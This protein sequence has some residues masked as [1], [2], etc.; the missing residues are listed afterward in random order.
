MRKVAIGFILMGGLWLPQ[1][2]FGQQPATTQEDP[3]QAVVIKATEQTIDG[4]PG[5]E[6]EV[7]FL[8]GAQSGQTVTIGD[9]ETVTNTGFKTF[10]QGDRVFVALIHH[11]DGSDRYL[12]LDHVRG[13]NLWWFLALFIVAVIW[14]SRWRGVRSL[15][16]LAF[17]FTVII[18]W[19][20]PQIANGANPVVV[21]LLG[22][23]V[24]LLLNFV[25]IEGFSRA[26][27]AAA[28]GTVITMLLTGLLSLW[29][30]EVLHL[31][32]EGTEEAFFL[33]GMFEGA[34]DIRGLLLAGII[35]GTL[36][37]LDDIAISQV[38]AVAELKRANPA[39][40][41]RQ[42]YQAAIRIGQSHLAAIVNTLVFAYAGAALPLLVLFSLS[43]LPIQ[44]ILNGELVATEI[45]RTI[46]GS[47]GLVLALP[48]T[49][50]LA[51]TLNVTSIHSETHH[52][53]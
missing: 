21:T 26:T 28:S 13:H 9:N 32:G 42:L 45:I 15:F 49:T 14:F 5:W 33:Q 30:V 6:Y 12:I 50:L 35:I 43:E 29:A 39:Q 22:A 7:R 18:G 41:K 46:V 10:A 44:T 16:G 37:I 38:A 48:I 24:V 25:L 36:G 19:V 52:D 1:I 31:T 27:A 40:S 17:S 3:E 11:I 2:A 34:I 47:I 4:V 51:V 20:V 53:S 8:S 23:T